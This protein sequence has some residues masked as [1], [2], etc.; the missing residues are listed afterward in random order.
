MT[1]RVRKTTDAVLYA[2]V[3][4]FN[5]ERNAGIST[6]VHYDKSG[7]TVSGDPR[8]PTQADLTVTAANASDLATLLTLSNDV[9]AVYT[10]HIADTHVHDVADT[11]N[12]IAAPL[13]TD[14]T[15]A[16]ALLNE[17]K[18]DYNLH[19]SET[20]VHPNDDAGNAITSA[21]ATDQS[22]AETLANELKTDL[23]AHMADAL[24]GQGVQ[25]VAP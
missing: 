9:Y 7:K 23:N 3:K 16:E 2:L 4:A 10:Q 19:R 21:D 15:T 1:Y 17:L 8:D 25:L 12:P 14:L 20:G 18:T 11:S 6:E 22:S 13:A 5:A 24:T